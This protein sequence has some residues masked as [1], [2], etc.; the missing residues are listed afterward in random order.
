MQN[1]IYN[2]SELLNSQFPTIFPDANKAANF[3][4]LENGKL[5]LTLPFVCNSIFDGYENTQLGLFLQQNKIE[6][7]IKYDVPSV[8]GEDPLRVKNIIAVASGKGGVGKSTTA[9]N[10]AYALK[11][12]GAKVGILD[13]D[14]YGP[15][16]PI[17]LNSVGKKPQILPSD[18][19]QPVEVNGV[20]SMS[21]GYLVDAD[22]AN[23]WR[24]P[25]ASRALQQIYE[26][27]QW[28]ELD[29]LVIDMPPGTGDI[30]LTLAQKIPV[31]GAVIV[32]TPQ[33]LSMADAIKG[34]EMFN[35]VNISI[36]GI[37]ENMSFH[38]CSNCGNKEHIFG[39]KGAQ[40]V[41]D[42]YSTEVLQKLPLSLEIS[43]MAEVGVPLGYSVD[44]ENNA[45]SLYG[46][47]AR[48]I[49]FQIAQF[50][51]KNQRIPI[52]SL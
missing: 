52:A 3:L 50:D 46:E 21:I 40:V 18:K 4:Q 8:L 26:E 44:G 30:Q 10:L 42:K 36:L 6:M 31:T 11:K 22:S 13:A 9:V 33:D 51:L 17:L 5:V 27:T 12:E 38:A 16:I 2:F 37:V 14:I 41:A 43:N 7:E 47:L 15:S 34:I 32:T 20:Q 1:I 23:I 25:M 48:K 49:S 39:A 19:M 45:S 28:V 24:G 29:F 35:K